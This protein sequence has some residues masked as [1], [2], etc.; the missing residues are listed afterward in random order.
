MTDDPGARYD[1]LTS[2]PPHGHRKLTGALAWMLGGEVAGQEIIK[3]AWDSAA[4][5]LRWAAGIPLQPM[6]EDV[7]VSIFGLLAA[8]A[9]YQTEEK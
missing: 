3:Y 8:W 2:S 7:A 1:P 9:F 5:V 6:P 4:E